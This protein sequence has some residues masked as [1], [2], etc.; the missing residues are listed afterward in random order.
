MAAEVNITRSIGPSF[1]WQIGNSWL[2]GKVR[3]AIFARFWSQVNREK[4]KAK[5]CWLWEGYVASHG[6]GQFGIGSH[7]QIRIRAHRFAWLTSR[8]P[9][10]DGFVVCHNC[11]NPRCVNPSHLRL[12]SQAGNVHESVRKGRKKTWGVQKLRSED[13]L[14]IRQQAADGRRHR[15]IAESFGIARNTVSQIVSRKCWA[16]LPEGLSAVMLPASEEAASL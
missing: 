13:V 9:I 16:H 1:A 4:A 2:D 8:G 11:D 14:R 7:P 3:A 15:E 12:D 5:D 6:Y 10:P